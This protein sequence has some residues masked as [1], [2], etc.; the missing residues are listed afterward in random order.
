MSRQ[1]TS[2]LAKAFGLPKNTRRAVITL[3][4][5]EPPRLELE[6]LCTD[7]QGR[8]IVETLPGEY[9]EPFVRRVASVRFMLRLEPFKS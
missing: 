4:P 6:V 2:E 8:F 7:A 9:G 3:Y 1:L 5:S